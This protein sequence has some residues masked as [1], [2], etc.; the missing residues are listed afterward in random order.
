MF[1]LPTAEARANYDAA[2]QEH[3]QAYKTGQTIYIRES[4]QIIELTVYAVSKENLFCVRPNG[5]RK[6]VSR[7]AK[8]S[9]NREA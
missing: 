5:V 8:I 3:G 2:M 9:L 7:K 4:G 6:M 1:N